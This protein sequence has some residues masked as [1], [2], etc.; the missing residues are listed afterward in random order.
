M[1]SNI[2]LMIEIQQACSRLVATCAFLAD[3]VII[4]KTF[5]IVYFQQKLLWE[6]FS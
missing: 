4:H 5:D 1:H 2:G 6:K 3:C